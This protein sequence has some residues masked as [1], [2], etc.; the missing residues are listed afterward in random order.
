MNNKDLV[1]QHTPWK[2]LVYER[3]IEILKAPYGDFQA[4]WNLANAISNEEELRRDGRTALRLSHSK[5][6]ASKPFTSREN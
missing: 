4:I 6:C 2:L 1:S 3:F 5:G